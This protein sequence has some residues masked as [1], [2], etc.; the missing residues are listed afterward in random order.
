[1]VKIYDDIRGAAGDVLVVSFA[2]PARVAEY[3]AAAALPFAVVSDPTLAGY[4]RLGLERASW[5]TLLRPRVIWRYLKAM[6][7]GTMPRKPGDK[8]D[9]LQL[10]GDFVLDAQR[11]LVY[12]HPSLDPTD[13]PSA[14]ELLRAVR[15][16]RPLSSPRPPA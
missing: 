10:G 11:R 4:R 12:A 2:P 6:L 13:R 14:A 15:A 16:A 1:V 3:V 7:R 8:E 9:V 5:T